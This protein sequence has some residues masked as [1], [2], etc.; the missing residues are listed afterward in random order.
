MS[1]AA[2]QPRQRRGIQK[3]SP[4]VQLLLIILILVVVVIIGE[5]LKD[6]VKDGAY[7]IF[8]TSKLN[9]WQNLLIAGIFFFLL[10]IFFDRVLNLQVEDILEGEAGATAV[11]AA[12]AA[13]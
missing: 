5:F 9:W 3:Y 8:H 1:S 6:L 7:S 13:T 12:S 4:L 11:V 2:T 10:Y